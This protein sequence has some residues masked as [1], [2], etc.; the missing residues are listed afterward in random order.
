MQSLGWSDAVIFA[1][2]AYAAL[3]ISVWGL[4]VPLAVIDHFDLCSR[5]KIDPNAWPKRVLYAAA[6]KAQG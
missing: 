1:T 4:C 2:L 5:W 3:N 6:I